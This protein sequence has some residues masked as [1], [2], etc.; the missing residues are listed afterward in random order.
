[1][2]CGFW[3][4]EGLAGVG[5]R[6]P[7]LLSVSAYLSMAE[8]DWELGEIEQGPDEGL[9]RWT[10]ETREARDEPISL[11][12][13]PRVRP[14]ILQLAILAGSVPPGLLEKIAALQPTIELASHA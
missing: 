12:L 10:P 14:D 9:L 8:V 13:Q 3:S 7:A 4:E 6:V 5:G 1:M 2:G 11:W